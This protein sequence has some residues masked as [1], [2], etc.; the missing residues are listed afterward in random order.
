MD[1]KSWFTKAVYCLTHHHHHHRVSSSR[2]KN[3]APAYLLWACRSWASQRISWHVLPISFI[4]FFTVLLHEP[5]GLPPFL[6]RSGAHLSEMH[7]CLILFIRSTRPVRLQRLTPSTL[8]LMHVR[9][10]TSSLVTGYSQLT[11]SFWQIQCPSEPV[12]T[13][14]RMV[15]QFCMA[16]R[17]TERTLRVYILSL[18]FVCRT[19]NFQMFCS[20]LKAFDAGPILGEIC[21]SLLLS[22]EMKLPRYLKCCYSS[23]SASRTFVFFMFSF[24]FHLFVCL[25]MGLEPH[26]SCHLANCVCFCFFSCMSFCVRERRAMPS[27]ESSWL[28]LSG[29]SHHKKNTKR[30]DEITQSCL[31]PVFQMLCYPLCRTQR[32]L[33]T[34]DYV[35]QDIQRHCGNSY[36]SRI[37]R[38]K[39]W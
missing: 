4:D 30:S 3:E 7:G 18:V 21:A 12:S 38:S 16:Y 31:T 10:K 8:L 33:L 26:T 37:F 32:W 1:L 17:S 2:L 15:L 20:L 24:N 35:S 6:F 9:L 23:I 36:A 28:V 39:R 13:I 11:L 14:F 25:R 27:A 22:A 19:D 34:Y 5:L 29:V